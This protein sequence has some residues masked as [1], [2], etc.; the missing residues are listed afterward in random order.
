[1]RRRDFITLFGGAAAWP[2]AA[3]AQ[4]P[5]R[6]GLLL[7][8]AEDDPEGPARIAAFREGLE[9]LGWTEA[10]NIRIDIRFTGSDLDRIRE[11]VS[12]MVATSPELIVAHSTPVV[13]ALKQATASIPIIFAVVND[14]V[15]Q[16][17]VANLANPGG[18]ITG[19]TF[20]DFEMVGKWL[21]QLK[22]I[23]PGIVRTGLMFN[24]D[25]APYFHIYLR[26]FAASRPNM[27]VEITAAP[28]HDRAEIEA[29]IARLGGAPGG[30]LIAAPD[31]FIIAKRDVIMRSVE[32]H[33]VPAVYALRRAV[34]EGALM[35]YGPDPS[36]IFR[37]A[38]GYVDRI[39]KGTNPRD[40]PVQQPTKFELVINLKTAKTLGLVVPLHLQQLA[41]EVIE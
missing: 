2:L 10:R 25:L 17:F 22:E 27:P 40:L 35:S 32:Q 14:P 41:D 29:T 24:P 11:H 9:A 4:P 20:I 12:G 23:A 28:V 19:F 36:D 26:E 6:I 38:A 8:L 31:P 30:G 13:A 3:R 18:N 7:G 34:I 15:G 1:L 37:R 16:G 5:R 21:V 33:R 39:F